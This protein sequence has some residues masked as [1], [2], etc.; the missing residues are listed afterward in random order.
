V[1]TDMGVSLA[2]FALALILPLSALVAR[3]LPIGRTLMMVAIWVALFALA[4]A[5]YM[6]FK[7]MEQPPI[8]DQD[9]QNRGPITTV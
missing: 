6:L 5:G 4:A 1:T 9:R 7:G 3:R 2:F 8:Q